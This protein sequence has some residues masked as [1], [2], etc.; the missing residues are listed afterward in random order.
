M[1]MNDEQIKDLEEGTCNSFKSLFQN[2]HGL[3]DSS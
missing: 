1:V 3:P 2:L